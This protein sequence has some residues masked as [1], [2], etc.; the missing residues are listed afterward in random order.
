MTKSEQ[1]AL[2][3]TACEIL[4]LSENEIIP[5]TLKDVVGD[6]KEIKIKKKQERETRI[7]KIRQAYRKLSLQ[8]HPQ[9][10]SSEEG[11]RQ[12]QKI[13]NAY[14]LLSTDFNIDYFEVGKEN[15]IKN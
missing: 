13:Q 2:K 9:K 12:Y 7:I 3:I 14:E 1:K 6:D 4:G 15:Q 5:E 11:Q 10:D 8:Y